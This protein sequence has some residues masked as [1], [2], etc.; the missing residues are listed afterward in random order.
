MFGSRFVNTVRR[1]FGYIQVWHASNA[2]INDVV[3]RSARPCVTMNFPG[4]EHLKSKLGVL[5][6]EPESRV[7]GMA[8]EWNG[9]G[10]GAEIAQGAI[11]DVPGADVDVRVVVFKGKY[12]VYNR[13]DC[14]GQYDIEFMISMCDSKSR[15]GV[16][17]GGASVRLET[18][19]SDCECRTILTAKFPI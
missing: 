15:C 12:L 11:C 10:N 14:F 19:S 1:I 7:N 5:G 3:S 16:C 13:C 2:D 8:G 6:E 4:R 9:E 17:S 18:F